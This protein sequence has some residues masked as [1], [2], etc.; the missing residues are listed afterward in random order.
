MMGYLSGTDS[1]TGGLIG[2][3]ELRQQRRLADAFK[4]IQ[5]LHAS[6][7]ANIGTYLRLKDTQRRSAE[8]ALERFREARLQENILLRNVL[9]IN[10]DRRAISG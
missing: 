1:H 2:Q 4:E 5:D 6:Q 9:G 10:T 8:D 7:I 3:E